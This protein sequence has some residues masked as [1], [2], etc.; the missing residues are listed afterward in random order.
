VKPGRQLEVNLLAG[1]NT[2]EYLRAGVEFRRYNLWGRAHQT[3]GLL[4][5]SMKSTR[6]EY[7]Y[8]VPELFGESVTGTARLFGLRREE[9]AFLREEYGARFTVDTPL[10]FLGA[11]ASAGYSFQVLR[12][13]D[14]ELETRTLDDRQAEVASLEGGLTR[15]RR[16]NPLLPREGYRW[17]S[18]IEAASQVFGGSAEYQRTEFGATYHQPWGNGRWFHFAAAHGVVTT[19]GTTDENLPVNR[20]FF[21]GGDGS[22]RGYNVGEAAPRGADGRFVGAKSYVS[23]SVE[24]EQALAAQWSAVLFTD[25]LGTAQQLAEYPFDETLVSVGLG[26]RYQTIIGPVRAEYGYNL[27]RRPGDPSG[28]FHLSIG[29]PF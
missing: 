20:R 8:T 4:V 2:Y 22:N 26:I 23:A 15:D 12:N 27:N 25:A 19:F 16:D 7:S 1:Y 10:R 29:F 28:T 9:V 24:F 13:R 21:P 6:G 18:R 17:Y 11:H 5:Q 14:N 3:R